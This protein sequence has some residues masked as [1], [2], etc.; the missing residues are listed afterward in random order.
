MSFSLFFS[1]Q[2][3]HL[4]QSVWNLDVPG[5]VFAILV[6]GIQY[7]TILS[8]F[9]ES[10]PRGYPFTTLINAQSCTIMYGIRLG[11]GIKI[12]NLHLAR[13]FIQYHLSPVRSVHHPG[14][15]M[16]KSCIAPLPLA[17]LSRA[18]TPCQFRRGCLTKHLQYVNLHVIYTS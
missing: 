14:K 8:V 9:S 13:S 5:S 18:G 16:N 1:W 3:Q 12:Y 4:L 17:R 2:R 7:I 10:R 11:S 15:S 6:N